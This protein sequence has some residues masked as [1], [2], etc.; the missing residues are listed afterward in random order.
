MRVSRTPD[1]IKKYDRNSTETN[2]PSHYSFKTLGSHCSSGKNSKQAA[3]C[4]T[5]QDTIKY[6]LYTLH[7]TILYTLHRS[8]NVYID[9]PQ[10]HSHAENSS[11]R[12]RWAI[13]MCHT[14]LSH[15]KATAITISWCRSKDLWHYMLRLH[16]LDILS[17]LNFCYSSIIPEHDMKYM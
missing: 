5:F 1:A 10:F 7:C 2:L 12:S 9:H 3:C 15:N 6:T 8:N 16:L 17:K 14:L 11:W 13:V 4:L